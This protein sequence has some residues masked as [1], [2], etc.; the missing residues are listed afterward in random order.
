MKV[1]TKR[2]FWLRTVLILGLAGT[3]LG[4]WLDH[5]MSVRLVPSDAAPLASTLQLRDLD[6]G[7]VA[8]AAYRGRVVLLNM[9]ASWCQ[10][11]RVE[12]PRLARLHRELAADGLAVLGLNM[13]ALPPSSLGPI[14]REL[15]INY[16]VLLLDE[17]LGGTFAT[18]GA[19]PQT[20]LIDR[21]GRVRASH[22]GLATERSLRKACVKLLA[23]P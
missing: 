19:I 11:C 3:A 2:G 23:E 4:L 5:L 20:W 6:G 22:T 18:D 12:I 21:E 7:E 8:L 15:G 13:E 17:G 10:P 16:P 14:A 9:W 1:A